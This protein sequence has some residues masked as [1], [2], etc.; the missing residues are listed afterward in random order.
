MPTLRT[1]SLVALLSAASC[2]SIFPTV[3]N[4]DNCVVQNEIA[5]QG[6]TDSQK[7][8]LCR[9]LAV[10]AGSMPLVC[11]QVTQTCEPKGGRCNMALD[12]VSASAAYCDNVV[13]P[14]DSGKPSP[15]YACTACQT[16][17]QC[18][19]WSIAQSLVIPKNV[20]TK[21]VCGDCADNASCSGNARGPICDEVAK[22][23]RTCRTN[24][25]C[26]QGKGLCSDSPAV[27]QAT[28][29][30]IGQC[31]SAAKIAWATADMPCAGGTG[32]ED[33]PFCGISA[34]VMANKYVLRL[35][36]GLYG[37]YVQPSLMPMNSTLVLVGPA[38][39][40]ASDA[41][42]STAEFET[43][44]I[45]GPST[46]VL[47]SVNIK[48]ALADDPAVSCTTLSTLPSVSTVELSGVRVVGKNVGIYSAGTA[49]C[50]ALRVERSFIS[51][52]THGIRLEK[53][54]SY[55][56]QNN[57]FQDCG[58]NITLCVELD[59]SAQ[60]TFQLNTIVSKGGVRCDTV[61][62]VSS[63]II[64]SVPPLAGNCQ[65][66]NILSTA[67]LRAS[68]ELVANAMSTPD[69]LDKGVVSAT[70]KPLVDYFGNQRPMGKGYDIGCHELAA[71]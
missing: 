17:A 20:C 31:V 39:L 15:T 44:K 45:D 25:D 23:C 11:D 24:L 67:T 51:A 18:Q 10:P 46:L 64:L 30:P 57:L 3:S 29:T 40:H 52:A 66:N 49:G 68:G 19:A 33:K 42:A 38:R 41:Q 70:E 56:I 71:P 22:T 14:A 8:D 7:V 28:A 2:E 69:A 37:K 5:N 58:N 53:A 63:S 48:P 9:E 43:V 34:A 60:G 6:K 36:P 26:D 4:P 35:K 1:L 21:G 27:S 62:P 13:P 59:G 47:N 16:D 61:Q 65:S 50:K 55:V 12:C 32:T 54:E